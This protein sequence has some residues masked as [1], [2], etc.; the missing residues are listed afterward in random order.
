MAV[1]KAREGAVVVGLSRVIYDR[2]GIKWL[3]GGDK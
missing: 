3:D 2:P 1:D